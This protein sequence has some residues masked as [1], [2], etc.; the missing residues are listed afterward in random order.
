MKLFDVFNK[1]KGYLKEKS[2]LKQYEYLLKLPELTATKTGLDNTIPIEFLPNCA[3]VYLLYTD[4]LKYDPSALISSWYRSIE[5]N[6]AV[7]GSKGSDHLT[8]SAIDVCSTKYK[9]EDLYKIIEK[10]TQSKTNKN[11]KQY[12]F[13]KTYPTHVHVSVRYLNDNFKIGVV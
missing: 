12:Y 7:R 8:G 6:T 3:E 9:A 4:I 5:V 1:L 10:I 2:L 11:K 13:L